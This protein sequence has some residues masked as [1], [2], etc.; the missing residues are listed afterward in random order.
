MKRLYE[1]TYSGSWLGGRAI[2]F[3]TSPDDAIEQVRIDN[4]TVNFVDVKAS[5][6]PK[7]GVVYNDNGEY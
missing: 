4:A 3:A 5:V 6:L 1:V 7:A 2:V